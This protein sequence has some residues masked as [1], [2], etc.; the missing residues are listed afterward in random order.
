MYLSKATILHISLEIERRGID[1][2][3][4][5][6]KR[7]ADGF[8]DYLIEQEKSHIRIFT[9][10]FSK[11]SGT[12]TADRFETPYLD[13][14]FLVAAYA[15]TEVFG[16]ADPESVSALQMFDIAIEMEKNSILFYGELVESL[17][18]EFATEAA[19]LGKLRDEEKKHLRTLVEKKKALA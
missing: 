4:A 2:Y 6:K 9:E 19:L 7:I 12:V 10:L 17:G 16:A 8:L 1:F 18:E 11:D 13:D 15:D 14:D 5:M 3:T